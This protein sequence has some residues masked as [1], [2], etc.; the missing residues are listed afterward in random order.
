MVRSIWLWTCLYRLRR[1]CRRWSWYI[2]LSWN[3]LRCYCCISVSR[4][5][6]NG[7]GLC[8]FRLGCLNGCLCKR[9]RGISRSRRLSSLSLSR[10]TFWCECSC[11]SGSGLRKLLWRF[12]LSSSGSSSCCGRSSFFS[13]NRYKVSFTSSYLNNKLVRDIQ[14]VSSKET[15][16]SVW[17]V[18]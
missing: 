9:G 16:N 11:R 10:S 3:W 5:R 17:V 7:S 1:F 2:Y 15:N 12:V 13:I 18:F 14:V 8:S 6:G 4:R